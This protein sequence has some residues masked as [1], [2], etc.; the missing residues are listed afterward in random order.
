MEKWETISEGMTKEMVIDYL[1]TPES[2]T[3]N[4]SDIAETYH[5]D[6]FTTAMDASGVLKDGMNKLGYNIDDLEA[7]SSLQERGTSVEMYTYKVKNSKHYIYFVKEVVYT[8][9]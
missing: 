7:L 1:G 9:K 8:K 3:I 6:I 4:N 2:K 5:T